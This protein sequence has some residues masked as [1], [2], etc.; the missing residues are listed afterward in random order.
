[1]TAY[2]TPSHAQGMLS[3]GL[4]VGVNFADVS[5]N[6]DSTDDEDDAFDDLQKRKIGFAVGGFVDV[7]VAPMFSVQPEFLY[8]Q[9][10]TKF[11][12]D[13]DPIFGTFTDKLSVD[14][15]Q[16]PVLG[17]VKFAGMKVRPFVVFGPGFGF[18]TRAKEKTEFDGDSEESDFKDD[19]KSVEVSLI[20]GGGVQFGKA[21]VE[22]RYDH[23]LTNMDKDDDSNS[24]SSSKTRTFSV[25]FGYGWP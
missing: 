5:F 10:G 6:E 18:V 2:A 3:Y 19:T 14:M 22:V 24:D 12:A 16:I 1:M 25:L 15:I 21:S 17:K 20:V 13:N 7:P 11:E 8:T 23:G 9:K 4:K